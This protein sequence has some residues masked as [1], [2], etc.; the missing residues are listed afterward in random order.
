MIVKM[1]SLNQRL[2][3][4]LKEGDCCVAFSAGVDST[5]VL[6]LACEQAQ[7]LGRRVYAVTFHTMLHPMADMEL[8]M[9]LA[10]EYG[11]EGVILKVDEYEIPQIL[12]NP[13]DRCFYCKDYLFG[14]LKAFAL[15]KGCTAVLDGT[16]ADD[17]KVFRPG[18]KALQKNGIISPLAECGI[19]KQQVR[20]LAAFLGLETAQK[21]STPCLATRLPYGEVLDRKLLKK[22][23]AGEAYMESLGFRTCRLRIH[24]TVA[25]IEIE[26]E[27]FSI[28]PGCREELVRY[29]KNLGFCYI[30]LDLQGLRSGSMDEVLSEEVK[31]SLVSD[32]ND[33]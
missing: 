14:S 19:T 26:P 7:K 12:N 23:E 8:A 4:I 3:C 32:F 31:A 11:A 18:L 16:N 9:Y 22:I 6:K 24:G 28:L 13:P 20:N 2:N 33:H 21:P 10:E 29:L 25:R 5:V 1:D 15:E 30:T 17:K 27:D